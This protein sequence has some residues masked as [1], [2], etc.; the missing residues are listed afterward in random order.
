[1]PEHGPKHGHDETLDA[2]L[3]G[4][5]KIIQRR[6]GYR[7]CVDAL[8]LADFLDV[9]PSYRLLDIGA[10]S[11]VVSLALWAMKP[12]RSVTAVEI[13]TGLAALAE[14]N[15][16]LNGAE[17]TIAV[18]HA[19][20]RAFRPKEKFDAA[21]SNPPYRPVGKGRIAPDPERAI[22]R[23]EIQLTLDA[24][25]AAAARLVKPKGR[26]SLV[27]LAE[28]VRDLEA[29]AVAHGFHLAR[30]R[31]VLSHKGEPP[32]MVLHEYR[33]GGRFVRA[34][35]MPSLVLFTSSGVYTREART[36]L[37]GRNRKD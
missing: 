8:L 9:R 37:E 24:L 6:R 32:V 29:A 30:M 7:F 14:R 23:H 28:R 34:K 25:F 31:N 27:Y 33:L 3:R 13:Q 5:V 35:R 15:V 10:G 18:A 26:F 16:R 19:D 36:I 12:F 21:F 20:I 1:M 4:R 17:D 22:A 11:G 2:V